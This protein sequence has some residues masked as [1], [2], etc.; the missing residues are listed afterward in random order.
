MASQRLIFSLFRLG[1]S[2][3]LSYTTNIQ[4]F[5]LGLDSVV[6]FV[7]LFDAQAKRVNHQ[8]IVLATALSVT[9]A[10]LLLQL[11]THVSHYT[12]SE[13]HRRGAVTLSDSAKMTKH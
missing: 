5:S 12:C 9:C 11:H 1:F 10:D 4:F 13:S 3:I 6:V 2:G 8:Y 7:H